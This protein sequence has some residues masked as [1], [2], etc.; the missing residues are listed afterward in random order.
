MTEETRPAELESDFLPPAGI[1][2][3]LEI[4][5]YKYNYWQINRACQIRSVHHDQWGN[6]F[7]QEG[8]NFGCQNQS[9]EPNSVRA[10][11][12]VGGLFLARGDQFWLPKSVRGD[13]FWLLKLVRGTIFSQ[14]LV[15]GDRFWCDSATSNF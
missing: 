9:G 11:R 12:S 2:S 3:M 4:A 10:S 13:Q 5:S 1:L 7:W 8:T 6:C 15:R 14:K